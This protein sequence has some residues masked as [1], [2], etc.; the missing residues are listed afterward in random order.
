MYTEDMF[1]R[2]SKLDL[3]KKQV[4]DIPKR[5][6]AHLSNKP[7]ESMFA[8]ICVR[9]QTLYEA[10]NPH[11]GRLALEREIAA[12]N[13]FFDE[14]RQAQRIILNLCGVGMEYRRSE[15]VD[16][17]IKQVVQPLEE[18]WEIALLDP[19]QLV[20]KFQEGTLDFQR[21]V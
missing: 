17:E 19:D 4:E 14:L 18:L 20:T 2:L 15:E 10:G 6:G 8:D 5:L 9:Y 21:V 11:K 13:P 7:K 1:R 3:A 12:F 16:R